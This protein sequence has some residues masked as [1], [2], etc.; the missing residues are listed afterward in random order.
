[1]S[2]EPE[3]L[4]GLYS[5]SPSEVEVVYDGWALSYDDD[6]DAWGYDVPEQ[7]ASL[8][9]D[10]IVT[11]PILDAGCGTGRSGAALA[12]ARLSPLIGI[13]LSPES[14]EQA[15]LRS[16][17][18]EL[19]QV[20]MTERLPYEDDSF[21]AVVSAGVLAY[22]TDSRSVI[23][24]FLR[25]VGPGGLV[26]FSQRSDLWAERGFDEL[27]D[28]LAAEGHCSV[29]RSEPQPYLP[30]HPDYGDEIQVIYA[31]LECAV[32]VE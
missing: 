22:L 3:D 10:R 1:M 32:S 31:E 29:A 9:A 30:G 20:D 15:K 5:A 18:T 17:Y 6:M 11:G 7:L 24:E 12:D 21:A 16:V 27:L 19:R 2:S 13:D 25:V 4:S 14:L 8:V 28:E 23:L 26:A